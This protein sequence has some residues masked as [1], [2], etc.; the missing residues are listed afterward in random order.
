M[1]HFDVMLRQRA[2]RRD[3]A[4]SLRD[5]CAGFGISAFDARGIAA[6]S[7]PRKSTKCQT[8]VVA[9]FL[10]VLY[11]IAIE[12]GSPDPLLAGWE[13][14]SGFLGAMRPRLIHLEHIRV[15]PL[16]RDAQRDRNVAA[17]TV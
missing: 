14:L 9:T 12:R 17:S 8:D 15:H 2:D 10:L 1:D 13:G 6:S 16:L 4:P 7:L 3:G 11:E 5:A